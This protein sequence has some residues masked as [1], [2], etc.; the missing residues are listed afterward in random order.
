M[1]IFVVLV[2]AVCLPALYAYECN[3][4][5]LDGSWRVAD[6]SKINN[7]DELFAQM[8][9]GQVE[10]REEYSQFTSDY[11]AWVSANKPSGSLQDQARQSCKEAIPDRV[12]QFRWEREI[13]DDEYE[14]RQY[15][16]R[17]FEPASNAWDR[18]CRLLVDR[19]SDNYVESFGRSNPSLKG[20]VA[21]ITRGNS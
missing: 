13:D 10:W 9:D 18:Y 3:S 15:L 17:G 8:F 1:K 19:D 5:D 6:N 2:L 4:C 16:Y 12:Y 21:Y 20:S 11:N 7:D 14:V